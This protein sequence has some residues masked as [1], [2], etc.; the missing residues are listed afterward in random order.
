MTEQT[1]TF[2]YGVVP[3]DIEPTSDARGIGDPPARVTM[4]TH[5]DV[6]ALISEVSLDRSLGRPEELRGYQNLLDGTAAL[7]PVLPVR[8]GTVFTDEDAVAALLAEHHDDF[9][10]A[11]DELDGRFEFIVRG[12]YD[13]AALL[14]EVLDENPELR[15]LR[16]EARQL[17]EEVSVGVRTRLGEIVNQA[18]EAKRNVDTQALADLLQPVAG[19]LL[20]RQPTSETDAANIALLV[21]TERQD[22]LEKAVHRVAEDWSG[23]INL[24]LL[25]P[26]A[27]YDFVATLQPPTEG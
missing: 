4:V 15:Q 9:R 13:Q 3:S 27:P 6:G 21:D 18:V 24:R 11:L 22:D 16:D 1:A 14:T 10:A 20:I 5:G 2:L 7:A 23:R 12:R 25:G 8:F 19:Q 17:P 26:L